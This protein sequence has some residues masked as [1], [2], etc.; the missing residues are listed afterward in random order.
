MIDVVLDVTLHLHGPVLTHATTPGEYG[1]DAVQAK[2]NSGRPRID[3]SLVKGHLRQAWTELR[4][5]AGTFAPNI[6][7][8]LGEGTGSQ[9]N[10]RPAEPA[11]GRLHFSDFIGSAGGRSGARSRIRIDEERGAVSTRFL[12]VIETPFAVGEQVTFKGTIDFVAL[13]EATAEGIGRYV[14]AGLRWVGSMGAFRTIGFGRVIG[15]DVSRGLAAISSPVTSATGSDIIDLQIYF[16]GPFCVA[17]LQPDGN[18]FESDDCIPGGVVKGSLASAWRGRLG[19]QSAGAVEPRMDPERRELAEHFE[20]VR[21]THAFPAASISGP[22]IR[23]V[24]PPLSIVRA[25][26]RTCDVALLEG[27]CLVDGAAPEFAIDWKDNDRREVHA[28]FQWPLLDRELRVRTAIDGEKRKAAEGQLF[29]YEAVV[30]AN[31]SWLGGVDLT[32]IPTEHRGAVEKQLR[33]LLALGLTGV[34]KTKTRARV[35]TAGEP[36]TSAVSHNLDAL[37]GGLYVVTLQT[38]ALLPDPQSFDETSGD[39]ALESAY[40][41]VWQEL[42]GSSLELVRYFARQFLAGGYYLHQRFNAGAV[43]Y[44]P[45]FLTE[46]GSVFVLRCAKGSESQASEK[47]HEWNRSGLPLPAWARS[48]YSRNGHSG[49]HWSNCPFIRE[50][51]YGEIAV[52]LSVHSDPRWQPTAATRVVEVR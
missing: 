50:N 1:I 30:P 9:K 52:N 36:I 46:G 8:L 33:D 20:H 37:T 38:D 49:D 16:K 12:Q 51:G 45:Y 13:D 48:R 10:M 27:P 19:K 22:P 21:F 32:A 6:G 43:P 47:I 14:T 39:A 40:R 23:P 35:T 3:G 5:A 44:A 34:G 4:D 25:K 2:D 24:R 11:R 29:A 17:R 18:L 7:D 42:S 15:V 31:R 26:G 41:T 28:D